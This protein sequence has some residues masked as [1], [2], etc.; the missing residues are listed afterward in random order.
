[1]DIK[2]L[3]LENLRRLAKERHVDEPVKFAKVLKVS[4]QHASQLLLGKSN[5]GTATIKKRLSVFQKKTSKYR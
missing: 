1:M 3:K 4:T 2:E 5:I